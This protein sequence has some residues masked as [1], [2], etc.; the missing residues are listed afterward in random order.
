MARPS[1]RSLLGLGLLVLAIS[2][3]ASW[4]RDHLA[5]GLG[6]EI[7]RLARPGD[8]RMLSSLTCVFC[9]RARRWMTDRQIAFDECSIEL[10]AVCAERATADRGSGRDDGGGRRDTARRDDPRRE[11]NMEWRPS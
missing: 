3:S 9:E 8:I 2:G 1:T 11:K 5:Q 4:W 7:G 10:D 6:T